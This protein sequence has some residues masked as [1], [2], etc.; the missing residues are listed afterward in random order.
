VAGAGG[1]GGGRGGG[2]GAP[3]GR[4]GCQGGGGKEVKGGRRARRH[5][6]LLGR[7][8]LRAR[9]PSPVRPR[10]FAPRGSI[11]RRLRMSRMPPY[12]AASRPLQPRR[13]RMNMGLARNWWAVA[14]RGALAILFGLLAFYKPGITLAAIVLL[15]GVFVLVVG[16]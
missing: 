10:R 2:G 3:G 16:L 1:G 6:Y 13:P 9:A 8:V 12:H 5:Q 15:F 4:G 14:L 11:P 7:E